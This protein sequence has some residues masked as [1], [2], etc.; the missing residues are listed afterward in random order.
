[1]NLITLESP[2]YLTTPMDNS[3]LTLAHLLNVELDTP[4]NTNVPYIFL[5]V[6]QK[7]ESL[8]EI[9]SDYAMDSDVEV[10]SKVFSEIIMDIASGMTV[11]TAFEKQGYTYGNDQ[12]KSLLSS[13]YCT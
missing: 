7:S 13:D 4:F 11:I 1:M 3:I 5:M 9:A 12:S 8:I 6:D 10:S 2:G